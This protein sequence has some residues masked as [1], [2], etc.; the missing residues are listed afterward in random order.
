MKKIKNFM[1]K[2]KKNFLISEITPKNLGVEN[3]DNQYFKK[4]D[5]IENNVLDGKNIKT[6]SNENKLPI[7]KY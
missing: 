4:L 2:K 5:E 3:N 7:R 6:I 1:L